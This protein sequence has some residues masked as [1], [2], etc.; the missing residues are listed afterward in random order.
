MYGVDR[1]EHTNYLF[2]D[3]HS[4]TFPDIVRLKTALFMFTAYNNNLPINLQKLFVKRMPLYS[5][6][7]TH[8]F[9]RENVRTNIRAMALPVLGVK[10]WNSIS[11]SLT[12]V[13]SLYTF[14]RLYVNTLLSNYDEN[15]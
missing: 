4:L 6:S 8:Q 13:R 14:K 10:L 9:M 7:R 5:V 11:I 12:S 2:Y 3:S 1:L 15:V